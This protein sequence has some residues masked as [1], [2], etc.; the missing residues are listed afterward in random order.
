[1]TIHLYNTLGFLKGKNNTQNYPLFRPCLNISHN[2]WIVEW[3]LDP[4]HKMSGI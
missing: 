4:D 3:A 2:Y 1:M